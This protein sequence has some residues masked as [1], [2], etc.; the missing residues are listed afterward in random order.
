[1]KEIFYFYLSRWSVE[2]DNGS[3][4]CGV[5]GI[6]TSEVGRKMTRYAYS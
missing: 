4:D 5:H 2:Q 6:K 1:M 3:R